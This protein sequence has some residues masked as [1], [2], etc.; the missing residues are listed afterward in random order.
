[1]W[2]FASLHKAT[3]IE[4]ALSGDFLDQFQA[5]LAKLDDSVSNREKSP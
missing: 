1:L 2:E 4:R 5:S 3:L